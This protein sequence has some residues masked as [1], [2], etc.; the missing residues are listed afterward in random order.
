MSQKQEAA[1]G[2]VAF[3]FLIVLIFLVGHYVGDLRRR[4]CH[5]EYPV[6]VWET[7]P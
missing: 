1:W 2:F 3:W 6:C 4:V 5:L 7:H